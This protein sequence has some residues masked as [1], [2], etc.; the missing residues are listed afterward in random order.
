MTKTQFLALVL[1][2]LGLACFIAA[3][4]VIRRPPPSVTLDITTDSHMDCGVVI[5]TVAGKVTWAS[6]GKEWTREDM[7]RWRDALS[8]LL[9][10]AEIPTPLNWSVGPD[11]VGAPLATVEAGETITVHKT[12]GSAITLRL[13]PGG[14]WTRVGK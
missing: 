8:D 2:A 7:R 10:P 13:L 4:V 3:N 6:S 5:D 1:F 12:D 9:M 11:L 14:G